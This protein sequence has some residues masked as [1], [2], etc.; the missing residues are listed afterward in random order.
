MQKN[1][2]DEMETGFTGGGI[3]SSPTPIYPVIESDAV[4][5]CANSLR[6]IQHTQGTYP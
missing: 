2:E 4:P 1:I 5:G 6:N 3:C